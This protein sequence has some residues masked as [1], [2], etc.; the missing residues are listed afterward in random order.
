MKKNAFLLS[1]LLCMFS[2]SAAAQDCDSSAVEASSEPKS[3]AY[4]QANQEGGYLAQTSGQTARAGQWVDHGYAQ[5]LRRRGR[6]QML[7]TPGVLAAGGALMFP[8][9]LTGFPEGKCERNKAICSSYSVGDFSSIGDD[10]GTGA[11]FASAS[12]ALAGTAMLFA[13]G[14]RN[15]QL[16]RSGLD[17]ASLR[18]QR[19]VMLER[20]GRRTQWAAVGVFSASAIAAL[21]SGIAYAKNIDRCE[22]GDCAVV[23]AATK[24][25]ISSAFIGTLTG[26]MMI[27]VGTATRNR[28]ARGIDENSTFSLQFTP[29]FARQ[30]GGGSMTL[31]W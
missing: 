18:V 26:A 20:Y 4:L 24:T 16:G 3:S 31:L 30:G 22:L 17:N 29:Y 25:V 9:I 2:A 7:A 12:T 10:I 14:A 28:G 27:G 1:T 11:A 19:S 6:R 15:Q 21:A 23:P 8:L 5:D 13:I